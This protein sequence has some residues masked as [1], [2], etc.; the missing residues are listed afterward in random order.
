MNKTA[1]QE[2]SI[3]Y[4]INELELSQTKS[5]F[6]L[7]LW[8]YWAE[9]V[10][11]TSREFQQVIANAPVNKWFLNFIAK[12]EI[13]FKTLSVKYSELAGQGKEIDR[14]YVKC[15][16]KVMSRFPKALLEQAKKRELK[17][18]T[19]KVAGHKIEFSIVNQ[20]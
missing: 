18:Q 20:N 6:V 19:T 13:E 5:D 14:L 16:S 7:S 2:S 11:T 9:S 8:L 17:P 12:E 3:D 4:L 1:S 10:T 15:M